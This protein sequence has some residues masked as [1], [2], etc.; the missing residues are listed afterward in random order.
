MDTIA[1]LSATMTEVEAVA[2][3]TTGIASQTNLLALNATIEAARAGEAGRGFAVVADEVEEL[4]RETA[5]ATEEIRRVVESVR[6]EVDGTGAI[7]SRIRSA[8]GEVLQAHETI[9]AAVT[10]Q[11]AATASVAA[12]MG[13]AAVEAQRMSVELRGVTAVATSVHED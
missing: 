13:G 7:I 8:M 11:T 9:E 1:R 3:R 10:E 6:T 4:A 12:A 2:A 5:G